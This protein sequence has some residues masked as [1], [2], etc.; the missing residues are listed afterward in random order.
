MTRSPIAL[1]SGARTGVRPCREGAESS[2]HFTDDP[3]D[4]S[5]T[6]AGNNLMLPSSVAD[7]RAVEARAD[8]LVATSEALDLPLEVTGPIRVMPW[9]ASSAVNTDFTAKLVDIHP[10]GYA[11]NLLDGIIRAR[12][13]DSR[14]APSPITPDQP[15]CYTIDLW[16]T[17]TVFLPGHR[18]RLEISSS[19]FPR[20]ERNLNTDAPFGEGVEYERRADRPA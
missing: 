18:I 3:D 7:Q 8:V 5:P 17:S 10:D 13:W 4:P 20:F 15:Y 1:A 16:A 12:Y 11:Q 14:S 2:D 6:C 9:A 19:N